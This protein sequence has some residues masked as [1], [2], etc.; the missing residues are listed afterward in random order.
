MDFIWNNP[1]KV[2]TSTN[3]L[4]L[5]DNEQ[6]L[7]DTDLMKKNHNN[8][9]TV[10]STIIVAQPQSKSS[11]T[12]ICSI[13]KHTGHTNAYCVMPGGGMA[14]KTISESIGTHKKDRESRKG[15][16]NAQTPGKVLVT[17]R[18]SSGKAFI[19]HIDPVDIWAPA[20]NAEFTGI[21]S[22]IIPETTSIETVKYEGWLVFEEEPRATIDWNIHTKPSDVA[23]I[24][25]IPP[26][27]QTNH[28]PISFEDLPFYVDTGTTVHFS[29]ERSH[30]LTLWPISAHAVKGVGGSSVTTIGI[31]NIKLRIAH[32]AHIILQNTLYILNAMV[33]L[34]SV[35]TLACDNKAVAHFDEDTCWIT[36]KSTNTIIAYGTLLPNKKLYSLDLISTQA[37]H[38]LSAQHAPNLKT[39]HCCLGHANH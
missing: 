25:K 39:L 17:M 18:D 12:P 20:V 16:N 24:S 37:K 31:S 28:T 4:L 15:G 2:K 29:P 22:D 33:H 13:C 19:L 5:L 7:H 35:S 21:A 34:I 36:N 23:A 8:H 11:N 6:G 26:I 9:S 3:I 27:Q 30:F 38:T 32:G 1:G 10:K 14:K